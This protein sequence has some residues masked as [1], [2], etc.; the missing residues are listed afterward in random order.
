MTARA[1]TYEIRVVRGIQFFLSFSLFGISA[2]CVAAGDSTQPLKSKMG[3]IAAALSPLIPDLFE[4]K[5]SDPKAF[6]AKVKTLN[7]AVQNLDGSLD[8]GSKAAGSDPA[9]KYVSSL[10]K[11]SVDRAEQGLKDGHPEYAQWVLRSSTAYCIA[12]H[13]RGRTGA[14]FPILKNFEAPLQNAPWASRMEFYAATRQFDPAMA[15]LKKRLSAG[16][17][18]E[19]ALKI[20]LAVA[21]RVK[22]NP[23]QAKKVIQSA[24]KVKSAPEDLKKRMEF[25]LKDIEAWK[26]E[27]SRQ[28]ESDTELMT[29]AR[30]LMERASDQKSRSTGQSDIK[31]LRATL[32]THD[33]FEKY[34]ESELLAEALYVTGQAY[35]ALMD[36]GIW[37]LHDMYYLACIDKA[38]RTSLS[39]SCY[40]A[41]ESSVTL[42]YAGSR[43]LEIPSSVKKQLQKLKQTADE[44]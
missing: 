8:H 30:A 40:K 33:L 28:F 41:Y 11:S 1:K 27:S 13:T 12:C 24:L 3:D 20:A 10:F 16:E 43:G 44:P 2:V 18:D 29:A 19:R 42:G 26:G 7:T 6:A 9:L 22:R 34:P 32:F 14:Q 31:Y 17:I 37:S 25:W 38:P 21:V 15:E 35:E 39:A 23:E 36:F 5:I 4:K